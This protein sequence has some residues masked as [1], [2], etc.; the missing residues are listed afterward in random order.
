MFL[1]EQCGNAVA[2]QR[3]TERERIRGLAGWQWE[4]CV[5]VLARLTGAGHAYQY[6]SPP[7]RLIS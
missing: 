5:Q 7:K 6:L 3:S 2:L 4:Q 1:D